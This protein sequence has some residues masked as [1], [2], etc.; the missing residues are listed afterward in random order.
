MNFA[1]TLKTFPALMMVNK[2]IDAVRLTIKMADEEEP[3]WVRGEH[4]HAMS[5]QGQNTLNY[6]S[7]NKLLVS[8]YFKIFKM[9]LEF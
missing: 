2:F 9:L 5:H 4:M 3:M 8:L 7:L 6:I 1:I